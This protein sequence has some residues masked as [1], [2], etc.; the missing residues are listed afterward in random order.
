MILSTGSL[1][2]DV[3]VSRMMFV[4]DVVAVSAVA[5]REDG[6]AA[7]HREGPAPAAD[8]T[9]ERAMAR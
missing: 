1:L 8:T 4:D 5:Q 2:C 7:N 3:T 9:L 6:V